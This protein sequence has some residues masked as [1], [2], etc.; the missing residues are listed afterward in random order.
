MGMLSTS[1]DV[2]SLGLTPR[3]GRGAPVG[4][5][6]TLVGLLSAVAVLVPVLLVLVRV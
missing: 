5:T 6:D 4:E 1:K 3:C 2:A